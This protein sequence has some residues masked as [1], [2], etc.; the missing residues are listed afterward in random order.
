M[1]APVLLWFRNDLRLADHSALQAALAAGA[2][3]LP[4]YVL[5]EEGPWAPGAASRWWLHHSLA[6][7]GAG[8]R[9]R[10]ADLLLRRGR[11]AEVIPALAAETGARAVFTGAPVEPAERAHDRAVADALG[12]EGRTLHRVR[13]TLLFPPE[14]IRNRGGGPFGVY[15]PFA[16]ACLAQPDPPPPLPAPA[17]IPG[18]RGPTSD[19]LES[20]GLLP[21]HPDWAGGLRATWTPGES[22]AAARLAAFAGKPADRY[23]A[24][25]DRPDRDGTSMLSPHLHFGE[26][27]PGQVW[28][29]VGRDRTAYIR[30]L[31]WREFCQHLLWHHPDM[32][33]MPLRAAFTEMPWRD[34]PAGLRAWQRGRTG[35]PLVDAG[36]RQLWQIGW[37]HNRVRMLVGSFLVKHLL[38]PWQ[39]GERWFWD[40]L[41][42]ADLGNNAGGWQ[43]IAGCGADAAPYF[44]VFNPVLQGRKFDP[45]GTYVRRWV[46]ELARLDAKVIHAPWEASDDTL[47]AAGV[48]L[49]RTYQ[50]PIVDLMGGRDRALAAFAA[51]PKA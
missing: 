42:D 20:W 31:L 24:D 38:L 40:T 8:L 3:V 13:T 7:L 43:W 5:D 30:E 46:P 14:A 16:K 4:V 33:E 44:R 29:A 27:S 48:T 35:V 6:S 39:E 17:T 36:M 50:R 37:V 34:D 51:L 41:V 2:P 12:A 15:T 45:D 22:G 19:R 9:A 26:L 47:A 1:T 49:G 23:G 32:P 25:R 10:G 28:Y 11:A 21:Q 18:A